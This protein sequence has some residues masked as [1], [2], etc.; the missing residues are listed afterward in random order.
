M[1]TTPDN[2]PCGRCGTVMLCPC[3]DKIA[4]EEPI[5]GTY[6]GLKPA[7][8]EPQ[9]YH[10][11]FE[12][13]ACMDAECVCVEGPMVGGQR[14]I[15]AEITEERMKEIALQY[16]AEIEEQAKREAAA[17]VDSRG[18]TKRTESEEEK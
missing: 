5:L 17:G 14:V 8:E 6:G 16:K 10:L 12:C 7:T 11:E 18:D 4:H 2:P 13:E 15:I 1:I 9:I 3:C